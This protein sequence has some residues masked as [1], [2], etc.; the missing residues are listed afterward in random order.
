MTLSWR[1]SA[2]GSPITAHEVRV[3]P[4]AEEGVGRDGDWRT[5]PESGEGEV[6]AVRYRLTGLIN[7]T[8]YALDLRARNG[9]GAGPEATVAATPEADLHF[10]HFANGTGGGVTTRSE[11]VLVNVETSAAQLAVYF[12][13]PSGEIIDAGALVSPTEDLEI[14]EAGA[15]IPTRGI[16]PLGERTISTH[17]AG[18][19]RI[20]S[21][22]VSPSLRLGGV[23]RFDVS[24][25]GVAGVGAGERVSDA[26]F[27]ARRIAGGVNTG[28]ALRNLG[29]EPLTLTCHLL[30]DG[31]VMEDATVPLAGHGQSAR[32][33]HEW[34]P[35]AAT[36]DFSGAVRCRAPEGGQFTGVALEMDA[37]NRVF[38]TLP[39]VPFD[40]AAAAA[41]ESMLHFAHFANGEFGGEATSS[42]LVF[43]NVATT[44][45]DPALYFYDPRGE[46]I[47]A[48][49]VVDLTGEGLEVG[50]DGALTLQD[51]IPPLGA[52]TISTHGLGAGVAGS[53]RVVSDGPL[54]G[55]LRFVIPSLG[56]AGV[57]AGVPVNRAGFPARRRAGGINT[58]AAIRNLQAEATTVTCRLMREGERV[59]ETEVPLAGYGQDS[60]FLHELFPDADTEDFEGSVHCGAP[61][62]A[63][64]TGVALEMDFHRRTFTTL[65]LVGPAPANS[66]P[67]L[68]GAPSEP[69]R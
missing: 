1:S 63:R 62:G 14:T 64:F 68:D 27:P 35:E 20:G 44:G 55:V 60:R 49:S 36:E 42:D 58:G 19:L 8:P 31:V 2:S 9:A 23:L 56:V 25:L 53:V 30:R 13:D 67:V 22:R 51:E 17:G 50:A 7:G 4:H 41:G 45:V 65:P 69:V 5:I 11:L 52:R 40:L 26:L 33:L 29:S 6:H 18:D 48:D 28:A 66:V 59:A 21:V 61:E 34:F 57:G 47:A 43:V 24:T 15:L 38:T 32:F 16:E 10:A 39:V 37:A 12:Y 3:R 54:G 46:R